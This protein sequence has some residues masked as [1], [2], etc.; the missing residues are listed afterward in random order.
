MK[1]VLALL[2]AMAVAQFAFAQN[3]STITPGTD[4]HC[5]IMLRIMQSIIDEREYTIRALRKENSDLRNQ[6]EAKEI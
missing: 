1:H 3:V 6:L 2:G 4:G 5:D